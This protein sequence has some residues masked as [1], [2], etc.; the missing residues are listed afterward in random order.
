MSH[1]H[2]IA[3]NDKV[4]K[5]LKT[6]LELKGEG[7]PGSIKNIE[8]RSGISGRWVREVLNN[9]ERDL[10]CFLKV[11]YVPSGGRVAKIVELDANK[12]I[13][14]PLSAWLL[15]R[16]YEEEQ[17]RKEYDGIEIKHKEFESIVADRLRQLNYPEATLEKDVKERL[18][19]L[20]RNGYIGKGE[21]A[22]DIIWLENTKFFVQ[23]PFIE[24]LA[25]DLRVFLSKRDIQNKDALYKEPRSKRL[26]KK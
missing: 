19:F 20:I 6:I 9:S 23:R 18:S 11:A 8:A 21:D 13:T 15:L 14:R 25:K 22:T 3:F 7:L 17:S 1:T 12:I 16:L 26:P 10:G 5:I 24:L 2:H 4:A